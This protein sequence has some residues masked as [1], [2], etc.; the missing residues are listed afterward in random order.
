MALTSK[1]SSSSKT[2]ALILPGKASCEKGANNSGDAVLNT[3][4]QDAERSGTLSNFR[5]YSHCMPTRLLWSP[6]CGLMNS[7]ILNHATL[8]SQIR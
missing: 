6:A 3:I 5:L 8:L 4:M 1:S 2:W 7:Y